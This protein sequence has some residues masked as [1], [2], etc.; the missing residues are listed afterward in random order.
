[1]NVPGISKTPLEVERMALRAR[2][3]GMSDAGVAPRDIAEELG[4]HV[5]TVRKWLRRLVNEYFNF[6]LH[7]LSYK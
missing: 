1:M 6:S 4:V 3:Q 5:D 7:K 2:M